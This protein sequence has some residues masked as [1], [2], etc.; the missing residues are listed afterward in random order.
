[1]GRV[2]ESSP[3]LKRKRADNLKL[4]EDE[5]KIYDLILSTEGRGIATT[6][7][8]YKV[9]LITTNALNKSIKSLKDKELI[10]E[11]VS[12]QNKKK[13][14]MGNSFEPS[15]DVAGGVW[16]NEVG[17]LDTDLIDKA[18]LAA[19]VVEITEYLNNITFDG[20]DLFRKKFTGQEIEGLM[21]SLIL[22]KE[23]VEAQ[24]TGKGDF[25]KIPL[26]EQCYRC[27]P[28]RGLPKTGA[29]ASIPCG[30][31]PRLNECTPD[32]IISPTTCVYFKKWFDF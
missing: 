10:K 29:L 24:T 16:Y 12:I 6:E 27:A 31:C 15:V 13:H 30:V 2:A 21:E 32:G 7:V 5:R 22:D 11:V 14:L 20:E 28:K 1:M 18:T 9:K 17:K 25:A 23:I 8:K 3:A 26:G 19:T 4:S